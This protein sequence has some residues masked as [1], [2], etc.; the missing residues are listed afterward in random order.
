[1]FHDLN[2]L[3]GHA[4]LCFALKEYY[5][6][7]YCIFAT[8]HLT[9]N[10][11]SL[12]FLGWSF[13]QTSFS[14]T[15][16]FQ[17]NGNTMKIHTGFLDLCLF[18]LVYF[19]HP[20]NRS[21][22]CHFCSTCETELYFSCLKSPWP[23]KVWENSHFFMVP[24]ENHLNDSVISCSAWSKYKF[25]DWSHAPLVHEEITNSARKCMKIHVVFM[26]CGM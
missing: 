26:H 16:F 23:H 3:N 13:K 17:T 9:V 10:K 1:M 19:D 2:L 4:F 18:P 14:E 22:S 12:S 25:H 8:L 5:I 11:I 6:L 15:V 20:L 24:K 7:R 21:L